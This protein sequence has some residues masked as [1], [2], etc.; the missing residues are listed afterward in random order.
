MIGPDEIFYH[1]GVWFALTEQG[2]YEVMFEGEVLDFS[3]YGVSASVEALQ[4]EVL[5][6]TP[7]FGEG[8]P[9]DWGLRLDGATGVLIDESGNPVD[10]MTWDPYAEPFDEQD[11]DQASA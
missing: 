1:D 7:L 8:H 10:L 11:G 6:G 5:S 9:S 2:T 4:Y 3:N